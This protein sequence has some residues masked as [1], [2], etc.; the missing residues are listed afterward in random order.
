MISAV[1][2]VCHVFVFQIPAIL[3]LPLLWKLAGIWLSVVIAEFLTAVLGILL[4]VKYRK[5]YAYGSA[6]LERWK[7]E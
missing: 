5:K 3:F 7:K 4:I 6:A 1:L 2:S